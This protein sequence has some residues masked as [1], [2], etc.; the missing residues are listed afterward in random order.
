MGQSVL[1]INR[2][3]RKNTK[4]IMHKTHNRE[5]KISTPRSDLDMNSPTPSRS[6][7]R[8]SARTKSIEIN[9]YETG[10]D[11]LERTSNISQMGGDQSEDELSG[12]YEQGNVK[13]REGGTVADVALR[14]PHLKRGRQS[15]HEDLSSASIK[16]HME[17]KRSTYLKPPIKVVASSKSSTG[18]S[19][20][21]LRTTVEDYDSGG[22]VSEEYEDFASTTRQRGFYG[23]PS[24]PQSL[25]SI[26][27]QDSCL[28]D[29]A[30][31]ENPINED[32]R[33]WQPQ[34]V[35]PPQIAHEPNLESLSDSFAAANLSD[36]GDS[37]G[38][39][40]DESDSIGNS[41]ALS[42]ISSLQVSVH[43]RNPTE[44]LTQQVHSFYATVKLAV[45]D[46]L[47]KELYAMLNPEFGAQSRAGRTTE[48]SRDQATN[49]NYSKRTETPSRKNGSGKRS[50]RGDNENGQGGEG[51]DD[52]SNKR[53]KRD[54]EPDELDDTLSKFPGRRFACPFF[55]RN[56]TE[57]KG[58]ACRYP[59]FTGI[60]RLK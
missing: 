39:G 3:Q 12:E 10:E 46:T 56:P 8:S 7:W 48:N 47:M 18:R 6:D 32:L 26:A 13:E 17:A 49:S 5:S 41:D 23:K 1:P 25:H 51:D 4:T 16:L 22:C 54:D 35:S 24:K 28:P 50:A 27:P 29:D 58:R 43:E 14:A 40:T 36:I 52:G 9:E 2:N 38:N 33:R 34:I 37:A 59:G 60:H 15:S 31:Q 11:D 42:E 21:A 19:S 55:Q 30:H 44:V 53:R 45:I 20:S 57:H